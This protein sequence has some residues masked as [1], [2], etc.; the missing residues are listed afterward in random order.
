MSQL[1]AT[2]VE[3]EV[4]SNKVMEWEEGIEVLVTIPEIIILFRCV[5]VSGVVKCV[6]KTT[7]LLRALCRF[8]LWH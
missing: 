4:L 7:L 3:V 2:C 6:R 5:C 8:G 1:S